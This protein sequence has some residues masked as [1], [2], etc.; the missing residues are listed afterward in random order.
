MIHTSAKKKST[1]EREQDLLKLVLDLK[2]QN[3]ALTKRT[4]ALAKRTQELDNLNKA[5][6]E[7]LRFQTSSDSD[8]G[9]TTSTKPSQ[10]LR[11]S[12]R[13]KKRRSPPRRA[14]KKTPP[15]KQP[16]KKATTKTASR[17]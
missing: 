14:K 2:T 6:S 16:R 17:M 15:Q 4:Q 12:P 10:Q 3:E 5:Q 11:R 8:E 7:A 1:K 13:R 9:L